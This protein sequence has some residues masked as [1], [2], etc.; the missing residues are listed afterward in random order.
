MPPKKAPRTRTTLVIITTTTPVTNA[1]LK[2]LIE[3]GETDALAARHA[4]RNGDDSHTS[5]TVAEG[6]N[7]LLE[8]ALTQTL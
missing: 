4:S 5:G 8:N 3:Q 2:A 6:Q 7:E 1:Q